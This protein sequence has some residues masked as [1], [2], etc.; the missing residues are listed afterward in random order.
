MR[1]GTCAN[2]ASVVRC[3]LSQRRVWREV[4]WT[5]CR[6]SWQRFAIYPCIGREALLDA[7]AEP[8]TEYGMCISARGVAI[9]CNAGNVLG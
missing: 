2:P 7:I 9:G 5:Q 6:D 8:S 3:D 4:C 1:N